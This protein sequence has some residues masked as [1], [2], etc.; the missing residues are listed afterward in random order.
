MSQPTL[1]RRVILNA[2]AGAAASALARS[3]VAQSLRKVS[4]TLSWVAEGA[5]AYPYVAK[6]K[7][8]WSEAGL[9]VDIVRGYGSVAATQAVGA[10]RFDFGLSACPTPIIL[11]AKGLPVV[12]IASCGYDST[13]GINVLADSSVRTPKDLEGRRLGVTPTSG[14]FP[15]IPVFARRAGFNL[16]KVDV[17]HVDGNVR[18]RLLTERKVDA[19]DGYA[20]SNLPLFAATDVQ[21]RF[22]LFSSYGMNF[23]G[24]GLITQQARAKSDPQLCKAMAVG[25]LK[26]LRDCLRQ[27]DEA[28]ELFFKAVPE[29]AALPT[30]RK[31][32]R[33][34]MGIFNTSMLADTPKKYGLGYAPPGDY[35][36]MTDLVM[37][38]VADK[39]D[40]RPKV[41]DIVTNDFIGDVKL[42]DAE[43]SKVTASLSEFTGYLR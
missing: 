31:Q 27:P 13:M 26:G 22:M 7:G 29:I 25:L 41:A 12:Q 30:A 14:D 28:L 40:T 6:S 35:E 15:F 2:A 18:P 39:S 8:Y 3:A 24:I 23:A 38:N 42:D 33:I 1:T 21:S 19:I 9:D 5:S 43:W 11:A 32:S 10:G 16:D 37:E 17:I 36:T 34:G 20:V 4:L